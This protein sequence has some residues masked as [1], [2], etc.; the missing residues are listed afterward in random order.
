VPDANE[1]VLLANVALDIPDN[2]A[3]TGAAQ[4]YIITDGTISELDDPPPFIGVVVVDEPVQIVASV[5][6]AIDGVG[7]TLIV[8]VSELPVH[9]TP[10][11]VNDGVTVIVELIWPLVVFVA[12]KEPMFPVEPDPNPV[13]VLLLVHV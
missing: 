2:P 11:F 9:V 8:N 10:A 4:L 1:V 3:A 6:S 5:I 7:S 12:V 13:A